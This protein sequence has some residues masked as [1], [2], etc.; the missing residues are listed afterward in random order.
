MQA[1]DY[2][3][4]RLPNQRQTH[5]HISSIPKCPFATSGRSDG[6]YSYPFKPDPTL[7]KADTDATIQNAN[8]I[9]SQSQI[10]VPSGARSVGIGTVI[11]HKH[12]ATQT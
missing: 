11:A 5:S 9:T 4:N 3:F 8:V 1:S 2:P 12:V 6:L 10:K 7:C